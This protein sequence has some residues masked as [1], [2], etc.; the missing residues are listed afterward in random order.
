MLA[1]VEPPTGAPAGDSS[2]LEDGSS[3][4]ELINCVSVSQGKDVSATGIGISGWV[5]AR[6]LG[7]VVYCLR[8]LVDVSCAS[9]GSSFDIYPSVQFID[10][11]IDVQF[12]AKISSGG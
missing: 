8:A 2:A 12:N 5:E 7:F 1:R 6:A 9:G 10:E 4:I 11:V 3:F